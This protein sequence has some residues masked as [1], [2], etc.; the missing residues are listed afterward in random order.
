MA[1]VM[2][3][4][5]I[6]YLPEREKRLTSSER[7][8]PQ[9]WHTVSSSF[10]ILLMNPGRISSQYSLLVFVETLTNM[11]DRCGQF[12]VTKVPWTFCHHLIASCAFQTSVCC[13]KFWIVKASLTW[14]E[15]LFVHR[16]GVFDVTDTHVL[17]LFRREKAELDFLNVAQ[18]RAG[19]W[20]IKVSHVGLDM[21]R[22][23][24]IDPI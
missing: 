22:N 10:L 6:R 2:T 21:L 7:I 20:K 18:R 8:F 12:Y 24:Q 4:Q 5:S 13:T 3:S 23:F 19:M 9:L 11:K 17:N 15:L 14:S 1:S 16:L